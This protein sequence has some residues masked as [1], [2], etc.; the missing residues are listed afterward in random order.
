MIPCGG[1]RLG[2]ECSGLLCLSL[3]LWTRRTD[4]LAD[5]SN[6]LWRILASHCAQAPDGR[7]LLL[8]CPRHSSVSI[9][10][11]VYGD[12]DDGSCSSPA[13]L[14]KLLSE[15]QG[16]RRCELPVNPLLFGEDP[17]PGTAKHLYVE[18]KCKP[19]EHKRLVVCEGKR[20]V[21]RCKPPRVLNIYAAVYGSGSG[22][23]ERA[24]TCPSQPSGPPPFGERKCRHSGRNPWQ[25]AAGKQEVVFLY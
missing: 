12:R 7:P 9:Q 2:L 4:G 8:H 1:P 18:Y 5:F 14:Q 10:A 23:P 21:L 22:G 13:A 17:C 20:L 6:Y 19:T 11:A 16:H 15:C 25:E 24:D 3:L